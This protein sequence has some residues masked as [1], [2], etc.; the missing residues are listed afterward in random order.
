[1][2]LPFLLLL[3]PIVEIAL[4]IQ[5]GHA[6]GVLATIALILLSAAVGLAVMRQQGL[7]ALSDVERSVRQMRDPAAPLAQGALI[8]LGGG[9]LVLPGFLTD[10][11]GLALLVPGVRRLLIARL[12]RRIASRSLRAAGVSPDWGRSRGAVLDGDYVVIEDAPRVPGGPPSGWT[13]H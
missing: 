9:L 12:G 1:M 4:F 13:R 8:L 2:R 5:V 6:I 11:A 10:A 3:L 7:A